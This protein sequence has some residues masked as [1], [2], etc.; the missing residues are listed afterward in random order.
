MALFKDTVFASDSVTVGPT[1]ARLDFGTR[2]Q[3]VSI[4]GR[5]RVTVPDSP[6]GLV[7]TSSR[8]RTSDLR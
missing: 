6:L 7:I 8:L 3:G 4:R 2:G 1:R 5:N